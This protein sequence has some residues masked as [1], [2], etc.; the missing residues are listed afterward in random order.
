MNATIKKI[1]PLRITLIGSAL[2]M[3]FMV[4]STPALSTPTFWGDF[5]S[6]T[7]TGSGN[8]NWRS[9]QAFA[10]GRISLLRASRG[11][12][13]R[14]EVRAGDHTRGCSTCTERSEVLM[15]QD[16]SSNPLYE[17]LS[18]GTQRYT[19]SVKFD[20]SWQTMR[21][22]SNGAWGIFLQLHGPDILATNPAFAMDA[23]DRIKFDM[24]TG[25]IT[26]SRGQDFELSNGNLNK[27]HWI[28]F[29]LTVK[30]AKDNTGFVKLQ[31]RDE[32]QAGYTQVLSLV[33]VPTLQY[34]SNVNGGAVGGHYMKHGLYRNQETFTSVLYI[35]GFTRENAETP[36]TQNLVLN[37]NFD[38]STAWELW[39]NT[40]IVNAQLRTGPGA[41]GAGQI[42]RAVPVI[43]ATYTFSASA[44]KSVAGDLAT[45][46]ITCLNA[47]GNAIAEKAISVSSTAFQTLST[48]IIVPNGTAKLMVWVWKSAG[49]GY[50]FMDNVQVFKR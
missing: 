49:T 37:P 6:G 27:G 23:S 43:G 7:V 1:S 21:G 5:E 24:R 11:T 36:P 8:H 28:D 29:L 12:Y 13:A 42:L 46:F 34:S 15:M 3:V 19:F 20:P 38:N 32:G 39:E 22:N 44:R 18:S 17:N 47:S 16:A 2:A 10:S 9:I 41:G 31:R 35:D 26:R 4:A 45:L 33:N 40:A 30:Y 14:V 48:S 25:D 50:L